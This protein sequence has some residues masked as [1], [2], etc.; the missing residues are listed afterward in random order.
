M[1]RWGIPAYR[2]PKDVLSREIDNILKLGIELECNTKVGVNIP[3]DQLTGHHDAVFLGLGAQKGVSIGVEGQD[4]RGV[5]TGVDFLKDVHSGKKV[6]LGRDVVVVG[7]GNTAMDCARV[8][9]RL[10]ANV[11]VVY[12]RTRNEMPAIT[13]EIEEALEERIMFRYH[14][15]PVKIITDDGR[16]VGLM[17]VQMELKEA[18]ASGRAR[19]VPITGSESVVPADTVIMATGQDVD[20]EGLDLAKT[21]E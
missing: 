8:A 12:R 5:F 19:P 7:G 13:A 14:T 17:C 2:L 11:S 15:N 3:M 1:M 16:V 20:Y 10:G 9:K 4:S 6:Q 18:D 21:G